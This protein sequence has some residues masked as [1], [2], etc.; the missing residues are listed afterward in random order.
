MGEKKIETCGRVPRGS[1]CSRPELSSQI[2]F[3]FL[4]VADGYVV[5]WIHSVRGV[6]GW[7][8][9]SER[10][11]NVCSELRPELLRMLQVSVSADAAGR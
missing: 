8:R 11:A 9:R 4:T 6:D 3:D 1:E 7:E 2:L 5:G 10:R